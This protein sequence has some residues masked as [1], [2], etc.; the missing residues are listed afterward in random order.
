[1]PAEWCRVSAHCRH[2]ESRPK[3]SAACKEPLMKLGEIAQRLGCHL[4][5]DTAVEIHGVAGIEQAG[6]GQLTFVSNRRYRQ[7]IRTTLASAVL[8]TKET[9]LEPRPGLPPLAALR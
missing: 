8:I 2:A 5:G 7:A 6:P 4:D 9:L 3:R 1:M